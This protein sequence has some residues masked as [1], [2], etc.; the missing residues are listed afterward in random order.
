MKHFKYLIIGGGVAGTTAAETIRKLDN[1]GSIAIISDEKYP[2]YSRIILP[3][4]IK[5][6]VPRERL[7]LKPKGWYESLNIE[8]WLG[9]KVV[10]I[11]GENHKVK[12]DSGEEIG[13]EK[14]LI[15]SGG[16]PI[17]WNIPGVELSGVCRMQY[18]DDADQI[19]KLVAKTKKAV[20][21][22][23]GFIGLELAEIFVHFKLPCQLLVLEPYVWAN[24][25]DE[26]QG[27]MIEEYLV[28]GGVEIKRST[29]VVQVLGKNKAEGVK[30]ADGKTIDCDLVGVGIG[31]APELSFLKNS[32]IEFKSGVLTNEYLQTN[33][34]GIFAAGD[35]CEFYDVVRC[36][37]HCFGNWSNSTIQGK[38]AGQNMAGERVVYEAVTSH[39][40]KVFGLS[41]AII[42][43]CAP[44][45]DVEVVDRGSK[46]IG[47][48]GRILFADG[49]IVGATLIN[50]TEEMPIIQYLIGKRTKIFDNQRLADLNFK[51]SELI[52]SS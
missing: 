21:V 12:L 22:G 52:A 13:F 4:Y 47:K 46:E 50:L 11:N 49:Q 38:V 9:V 18:L 8:F 51:F 7:F 35:C 1:D 17:K 29:K 30:T 10:K 42:G 24:L 39:L 2:I 14:L 32:G 31:V 43:D 19:I 16:Q 5:G 36:L 41:L 23:G 25:V 15:A 27:K 34:E 26:T 48:Y 40:I 20:V 45:E 37:V 6:Q 33:I 28:K 3:Q 44:R